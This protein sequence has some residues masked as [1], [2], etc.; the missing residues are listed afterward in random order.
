MEIV[1]NSLAEVCRSATKK[2]L[3]EGTIVPRFVGQWNM[4]ETGFM[5]MRELRNI[6]LVV[7]DPY[8]RWY[9]GI[10]KGTI[11]EMLDM[12]LG[13]NPG[14]IIDEWKLYRDWLSSNGRLP[15]TYGE[16]LRGEVGEID[17]LNYIINMLNKD[18]TTRQAVALIR[19]P[20]DLTNKY[21]PCSISAF[22]QVNN[23]NK[24]DFTWCMRSNDIMLGG[25]WR[26]MFMNLHLFEQIAEA[27]KLEMGSYYHYDF[28]LHIYEKDLD[29]ANELLSITEPEGIPSKAELLIEQ[30]KYLI[31]QSLKYYYHSLPSSHHVQVY[32]RILD[33]TNP[34][35]RSLLSYVTNYSDALLY[36]EIK[37]LNGLKPSERPR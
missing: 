4:N 27:T 22:W 3:D 20:I 13:D 35:F 6:Q 16:R 28:N 17:Q 18:C 25:L 2:L 30:D 26:N 23:D 37:W 34:Y 5:N 15:Y 29:K 7:K 10:K 1:G 14:H 31:R 21:T 9:S 36:P 33:I 12:L 11:I 24:L 8:R 19:R 32:Q